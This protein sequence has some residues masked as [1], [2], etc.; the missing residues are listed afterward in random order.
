MGST[1]ASTVTRLSIVF[2]LAMLAGCASSRY[3]QDEE[4]LLA[5]N[6]AADV[7]A[8]ASDTDPILFDIVED[9]DLI[10]MSESRQIVSCGY[11]MRTGNIPLYAETQYN[12]EISL[13][14]KDFFT[15]AVYGVYASCVE[16]IDKNIRLQALMNK[17]QWSHENRELWEEE[18]AQ[19]VSRAVSKVPG[20]DSYRNELDYIGVTRPK[21]LNDLSRDVMRD[22]ETIEYDC[23]AMSIVE[24][25]LMHALDK[26]FLPEDGVGLKRPHNYYVAHGYASFEN[27]ASGN[28]AF[29]MSGATGNIV[30][31]TV[32][33]LDVLADS[34]YYKTPPYYGV[35]DYAQGVP[36]IITMN[37]AAESFA[38]Y[39]ADLTP[40]DAFTIIHYHRMRLLSSAID[41]GVDP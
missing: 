12:Q 23:E 2:A 16:E 9:G 36:T 17:D 35:R 11:I 37:D 4:D 10:A 41:L 38:V 31:C 8:N 20:L 3:E 39:G 28:H 14:P 15:F 27:M 21:S 33:S 34:P 5:R 6:N 1:G 24:G 7:E 30:E 32:L 25:V 40:V 26:R 22:T 18:I 13:F 29:V 19:I